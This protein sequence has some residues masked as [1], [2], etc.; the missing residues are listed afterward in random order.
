VSTIHF[1]KPARKEMLLLCLCGPGFLF[2]GRFSIVFHTSCETNCNHLSSSPLYPSIPSLHPS[3]PPY[4]YILDHGCARCRTRE[5]DGK[6]YI[7][8]ILSSTKILRNL[9]LI[10]LRAQSMN[11]TDEM[12]LGEN[13][14]FS[15]C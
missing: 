9:H 13:R 10:I 7:N 3:L 11:K 2:H 5:S 6:K 4:L 15:F 14:E 1:L 12:P 8:M